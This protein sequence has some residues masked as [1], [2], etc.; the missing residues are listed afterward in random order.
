M[1]WAVVVLV[2]VATACAPAEP[3]APGAPGADEPVVAIG[4]DLPFS[5]G[6]RDVAAETW[7]AMSLYLAQA[8]GRAGRH[9]VE[10]VRYDNAPPGHAVW[11]DAEC[12]RNA[13]D[14]VANRR[15]VAVI[16]THSSVCAKAE[17]PI[18]NQ[19]PGGPMLMISHTDTDPA[20]TRRGEA[21]FARVLP[22]DDRQGT[23]LARFAA[24]SLGVKRCFVLDDTGAYGASLA[25]AFAVAAERRGIQI[26]G[27]A[28]WQRESGGYRTLFGQIRAAGAD[29]VFLGGSYDSNG[30]RLVRDKVAVLGDNGAVQLLAADGFGG[31]PDLVRT[32]AATGM[33]LSYPGRSMEAAMPGIPARF[34]ADY[35]ATYHTELR[36]VTALYG[37]Q[38]LQAVL[39]AI[40]RSDGT[41]A[42][43]LGQ[44]FDGDGIS[45]TADR[46]FL[47][48]PVAID[49][50]TGDIE[51][52]DVTIEQIKDGD[53]A[54]VTTQAI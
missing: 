45:L 34:R 33:Y 26:A 53:Q 42:G 5:G 21:G 8:G 25:M 20:L 52:S 2:L 46:A 27:R 43:V 38:A 16:G 31:Y 40:E 30:D 4:V 1:R 47:G 7:N 3:G 17:V 54:F 28:Q 51:A 48:R 18:L 19:A 13:H 11:T 50:A 9:P 44:V 32:P 39:A 49:P 37:V 23:A 29:C 35:G 12:V 14:H 36:S 15:E 41:R 24:D 10:L 6:Q 22:S